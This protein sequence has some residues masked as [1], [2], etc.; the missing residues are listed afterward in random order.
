MPRQTERTRSY[1]PTRRRPRRKRARSPRFLSILLALVI[2]VVGVYCAKVV[3]AKITR[4]YLISYGESREISELKRQIA[5]ST[6]EN[7]QLKK[8]I[9]DVGTP[10]G[11]DAE[12]RKLG[13]VKKG[14]VAIVVEQPQKTG[15]ESAE[16]R[17]GKSCWQRA[18]DWFTRLFHRKDPAR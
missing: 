9:T 15:L 13:W 7:R 6:T 12:A 8:D 5:T 4:P 18:G 14:E 2:L 1:T 3:I 10:Q 17:A 11:K 16:T